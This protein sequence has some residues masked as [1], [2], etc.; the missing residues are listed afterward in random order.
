MRRRWRPNVDVRTPEQAKRRGKSNMLSCDVG[1]MLSRRRKIKIYIRTS[2]K[3]KVS[4]IE[5]VIKSLET[6][7]FQITNAINWRKFTAGHD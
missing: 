7:S 2:Q 3:Q 4:Y 1:I 5:S 6:R